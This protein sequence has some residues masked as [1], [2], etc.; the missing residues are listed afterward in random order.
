MKRG[1]AIVN[2][3]RDFDYIECKCF[4]KLLVNNI[5]LTIQV[6]DNLKEKTTGV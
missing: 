3:A 2:F 4:L 1:G 5:R 6:G